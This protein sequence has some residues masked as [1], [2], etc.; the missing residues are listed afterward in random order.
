MD[1]EI[2]RGLGQ[3]FAWAMDNIPPGWEF[4]DFM[5]FLCCVGV[6]TMQ[7][8]QKD[9]KGLSVEALIALG[10]RPSRRH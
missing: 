4:E 10:S 6:A 1:K 3:H 8:A 7:R 9:H 5:D 2:L